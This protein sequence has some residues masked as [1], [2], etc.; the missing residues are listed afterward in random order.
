VRPYNRGQPFEPGTRL[1]W[2]DG[3]YLLGNGH[4][5]ILA[6]QERGWELLS[7]SMRTFLWSFIER[8][9]LDQVISNVIEFFGPIEGSD[10]LTELFHSSHLGVGETS[11]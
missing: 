1:G 10:P 3:S 5:L 4:A 2:A 8:E 11:S 6:E 9:T 7:L